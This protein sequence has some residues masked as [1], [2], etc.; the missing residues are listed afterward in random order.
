M[1]CWNYGLLSGTDDKVG[2]P[3]PSDGY[4]TSG[5]DYGGQRLLGGIRI[6]ANEDGRH[7]PWLVG[8]AVGGALSLSLVLC[9]Q[10]HYFSCQQS[11][12]R[13]RV[14]CMRDWEAVRTIFAFFE[15]KLS[16]II[17]IRINN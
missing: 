11:T 1:R 16:L 13:F 9:L 2:L 5:D 7:G 8:R 6:G 17:A 14:R 12:D 3:R 10:Y 4:A 15:T